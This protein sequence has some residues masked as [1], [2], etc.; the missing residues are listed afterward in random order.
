MD[1]FSDN[2]ENRSNSIM[3]KTFVG[4]SKSSKSQSFS[5]NG[6]LLNDVGPVLTF[7]NLCKD[8]R[9]TPANLVK[10]YISKMPENEGKCPEL[11]LE[12]MS[13]STISG[14][15]SLDHDFSKSVQFQLPFIDLNNRLNHSTANVNYKSKKLTNAKLSLDL[16]DCNRKHEIN[17]S[18]GQMQKNQ[19]H[20][21]SKIHILKSF[22]LKPTENNPFL[23]KC[24]NSVELQTNNIWNAPEENPENEYIWWN[25]KVTL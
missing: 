9:K 18:F 17:S 4:S 2:P 22:N 21:T 24:Q 14:K 25:Q 6:E 16:A 19:N 10:N 23:K 11:V 1:F 12:N 15:E 7:Q 3:N 13:F 20:F 8:P 5:F